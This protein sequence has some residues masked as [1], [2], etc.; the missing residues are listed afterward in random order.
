M[1]ASPGSRI[2]NK[3]PNSDLTIRD[4]AQQAGVSVATVSYVLNGK[5]KVSQSMRDKILSLVNKKG[6]KINIHAQNLRKNDIQEELRIFLPGLQGQFFSEIISG[7]ENFI[8]SQTDYLLNFCG[9]LN[10]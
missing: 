7:V 2:R 4:I 3:R 5:G 8:A 9:N 1:E 10:R 6:Y